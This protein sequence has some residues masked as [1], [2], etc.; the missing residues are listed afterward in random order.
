MRKN[1]AHY[2]RLAGIAALVAII[3]GLIVLV[4]GWL[5]RWHTAIQYSNGFF[6]AGAIVLVTGF[7]SVSG[8]FRMRSD[9]GVL[10][11]QSAGDM[12]LSDRTKLWVA[13][14]TQGYGALILLTIAG[15]IL[16]G[17]AILV[18]RTLG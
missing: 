9:F 16:V 7:A 12:N 14:M 18:G 5:S 17:A 8:G 13:D 1:Y 6:I 4:I 11:S 15:L 2:F 10:Y 3:A